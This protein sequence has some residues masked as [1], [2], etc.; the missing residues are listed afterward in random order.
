[1][2]VK[3]DAMI[4]PGD[5]TDGMVSLAITK[6]YVSKVMEDL[7]TLQVPVYLAL[8][9][10]DS[11]YFH[12]NQEWMDEEAQ[13]KYYLGR[14]SPWYHVDFEKQSLRYLFLL[15]MAGE[16]LCIIIQIAR[17]EKDKCTKNF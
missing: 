11:N 9:N 8:G 16:S 5:L 10:H 4:H 13:S 12:N 1:M 17:G 2:E 15:K 7:H 14:Q 3:F 6:E